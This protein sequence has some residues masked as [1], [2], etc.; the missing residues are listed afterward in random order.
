MRTRTGGRRS[1]K[2]KAGGEL[3]YRGGVLL[4]PEQRPGPDPEGDGREDLRTRFLVAL[5]EGAIANCPSSDVWLLALHRAEKKLGLTK[6][7]S[8]AAWKAL[9]AEMDRAPWPKGFF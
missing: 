2:E 7:E 4:E 9:M 3:V 5:L 8:Q 1:R 6:E